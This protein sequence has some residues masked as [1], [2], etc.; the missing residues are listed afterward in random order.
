MVLNMRT[1]DEIT[2]TLRDI[3]D[4][5]DENSRRPSDTFSSG[6][7]SAEQVREGYSNSNGAEFDGDEFDNCGTWGF[8]HDDQASVIGEDCYGGDPTLPSHYQVLYS[9]Y[10]KMCSVFFCF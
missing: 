5:F 1:K 10:W 9:C 4:Q 7:N 6:Q 2:P 8:D 3:V